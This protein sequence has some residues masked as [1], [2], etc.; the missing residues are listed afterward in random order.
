MTLSVKKH[1][2]EEKIHARL[3]ELADEVRKLRKEL[4]ENHQR[5]TRSGRLTAH[6]RT[7]GKGSTEP[8]N[9]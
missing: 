5:P 9:E 3:R 6:D 4:I 2:A 8:S 1:S 7:R